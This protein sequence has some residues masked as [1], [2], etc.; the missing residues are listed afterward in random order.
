L[1]PCDPPAVQTAI[2]RVLAIASEVS[3][4]IVISATVRNVER[5]GAVVWGFIIVVQRVAINPWGARS[6]ITGSALTLN[7]ELTIVVVGAGWIEACATSWVVSTV[8]VEP[9]VVATWGIVARRAGSDPVAVECIVVILVAVSCEVL[10]T[11][12]RAG[13][14]WQVEVVESIVACSIIVVD[15]A[16][17]DA[18]RS[19][20]RFA[21]FAIA[22]KRHPSFVVISVIVVWNTIVCGI[23]P[24]VARSALE[25]L[26]SPVVLSASCAPSAVTGV[27]IVR[28][29]AVSI[30][31]SLDSIITTRVG[32]VEAVHIVVH[33]VESVV[34]GRVAFHP[35]VRDLTRGVSLVADCA[36]GV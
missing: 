4:D 16:A 24:Q 11:I 5:V 32:D 12:A 7:A 15:W 28:A 25:A 13:R 3:A 35:A 19:A 34:V 10:S 33:R 31:V 1:A 17:G 9:A 29:I 27:G 21:N 8:S 20:R 2:A 36:V 14:I 23:G 18:F 6:V 26:T 22:L 30:E